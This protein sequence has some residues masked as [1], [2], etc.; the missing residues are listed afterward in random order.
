MSWKDKLQQGSFR[1][2]EF[3]TENHTLSGGRRTQTHEF[4]DR[5][6]PFSEDLGRKARSY[7]IS[8]HLIGD[9]VFEQRDKLVAALEQRG[10]G[11]LIHP[12]HGK[13]QVNIGGYSQT[14]DTGEGRITAFSM[15]FSEAGSNVYPSIEEDRAQALLNFS[16]VALD[17]SKEKFEKG[18]SVLGQAGFVIKSAI[19]K[20]EDA[21]AAFDDAT[22][23]FAEASDQITELAF[24]IRNLKEKVTDLIQKPGELADRL[25]DSFK[26][27]AGVATNANDASKAFSTMYDFGED[28]EVIPQTEARKKELENGDAFNDYMREVA[29]ISATQ[30]AIDRDFF[31]LDD[32]IK[33]QQN[34]KDLLQRQADKSDDINFFQSMGDLASSLVKT[35]PDVDSELPNIVNVT[36]KNT[37]SSLLLAYDLFEDAE[38]EQE[39]IDRN[40][41][42]DNAFIVGGT[43]IE[44]VNNG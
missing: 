2:V 10:A 25:L 24:S 14:E 28:V 40:K 41:I 32:S 1:G 4:V 23:V 26:L 20:V 3:F 21:A 43:E 22:K 11:E 39:I 27:L 34:L 13:I 42:K 29:I 15:S 36:L 16:A 17:A 35:V 6:T 33:E 8:I 19:G 7:S 30:E 44:V 38:K 18:F 12:Y 37:T 9:D 31:S 5:D